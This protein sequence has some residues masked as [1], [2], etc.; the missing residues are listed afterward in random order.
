VPLY[1]W[2][3]P[4]C[5]LAPMLWWLPMSC[6]IHLALP[7]YQQLLLLLPARFN[8]EDLE[9]L[10]NDSNI[11]PNSCYLCCCHHAG[12]LLLLTQSTIVAADRLLVQVWPESNIAT[13]FL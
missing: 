8:F 2:L 6:T 7:A 4:A 5:L 13:F 3:L 11:A 9:Q 1:W 12:C 10:D